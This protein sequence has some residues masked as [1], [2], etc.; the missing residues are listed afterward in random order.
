MQLQRD[1]KIKDVVHI[2]GSNQ[3]SKSA[4]K[5]HILEITGITDDRFTTLCEK[6]FLSEVKIFIARLAD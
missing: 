6:K 1:N 5:E 2:T 4:L 3:S